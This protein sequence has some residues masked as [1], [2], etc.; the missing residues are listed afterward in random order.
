MKPSAPKEAPSDY[1]LGAEDQ[2]TLWS[3][4]AEEL[5]D[6]AMRVEG[7][8]ALALPLVGTLKAAGL[9]AEPIVG[10]DLEGAAEILR[11]AAGGGLGDRVSEPAGF[12]NGR[13][14][15]AGC[16][17]GPGTKTLLEMLSLA[18]GPAGRR[19]EGP[20]DAARRVGDD[21]GRGRGMDATGE[22]STAEIDLSAVVSAERPQDNIA[23]KPNDVIR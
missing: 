9:T 16:A 5:N 19:V 21:S 10:G 3:P 7:N 20:R 6:K 2:I 14:Q 15:H 11:E 17:P 1:I 4:E 12:S 22:F 8:G 18:G 13:S 23:V